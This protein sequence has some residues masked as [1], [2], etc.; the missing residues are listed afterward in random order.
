MRARRERAD[1]EHLCAQVER[2]RGGISSSSSMATPPVESTGQ[3]AGRRDPPEDA[4]QQAGDEQS[5]EGARH[6]HCR[7]QGGQVAKQ[8]GDAGHHRVDAAVGTSPAR[9]ARSQLGSIPRAG[10]R[11]VVCFGL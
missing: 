4:Q 8:A 10:R 2:A 7:L 1:S 11:L 3:G 5:A 6:D 9:H